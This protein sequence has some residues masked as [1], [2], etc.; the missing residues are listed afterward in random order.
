MFSKWVLP[1]IA[2]GLLGFAVFH[3]VDAQQAPW[4]VSPP[5]EPARSPFGR[6]VA[7]SGIV[8]PQTQNIA[9]GS[10]L[11]GVVAEVFVKVGQKVAKGELLFRLDDRQLRAEMK[12]RQAA[13]AAALAQLERLDNMPRQEEVPVAEA[14]VREAEA[15]LA[16]QE[17]QLHRSRTLFQ[18]RAVSEEEL[19]RRERA[20][21][22]A[23][24][25][26][27]RV[28]AEAK[29]LQAGA[30]SADK[31]VTRAALEQARAQL[32]Q[33][34]TELE[35]S[36]VRAT[37]DGEVLQVNVRPGEFVGTPPGQPLVILGNVGRLHVRVDID[38]HDI[39]RFQVG[40]PARARLRGN[41]QEFSLAFVR[42]EPF[43]IPKKSL[44]GDNTERVDTRVLQ[45][46]FAID[47]DA[48]RIYVGQ[49]LDVYIQE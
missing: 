33:A 13:L 19:R 42:V 46:I 8:E 47:S 11:A 26:L 22:V 9:I 48:P 12:V 7:G 18:R 38:E 40:A 1:M 44:T 10:P 32:A 37:I 43:V 21:E 39:Q 36:L 15:Q 27:A 4:E 31:A 14:K 16:D 41:L 45:V 20:T 3:V 6:T 35:R 24:Q 5:V 30:W 2:V 49:Q 28:Q 25:Q 17:D 23:R 29:L 34:Q